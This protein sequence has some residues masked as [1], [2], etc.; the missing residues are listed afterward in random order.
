M[1]ATE[2]L[3]YGNGAVCGA[4][5]RGGEPCRRRTRGRCY[6]H[7]RLPRLLRALLAVLS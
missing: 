5:T 7:R 6:Q 2:L 3:D 1:N 4:P